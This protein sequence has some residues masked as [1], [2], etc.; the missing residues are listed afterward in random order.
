ML[1]IA[2][3]YSKISFAY[4]LT[5]FALFI[6]LRLRFYKNVFYSL[7]FIIWTIFLIFFYFDVVIGFNGRDLTNIKSGV[8]DLNY[9]N[10]LLFSYFSISFI[11]LKLISLKIYSF[12]KFKYNL[13][14][15]KILD[16]EILFILI[17]ALLIVQYNYFKGIQLY[18][19]YILIIAHLNL[20]QNFLFKKKIY[21]NL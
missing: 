18:I 17:L 7:A 20:I 21:E 15:K 16:I 5:I 19:S 13:I 12:N 10:E 3:S 2:A 14:K 1:F 4:V 11:I 9:M 8:Q 6:Y